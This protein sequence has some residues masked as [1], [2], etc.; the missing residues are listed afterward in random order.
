[1]KIAFDHHSPFLLAHGGFQIQI[2]QTFKAL[3]EEGV[4]V[5]WLRWWDDSQKPD[6]IHFFGTVYAGYLRY[7]S[8]KG[9]KTVINELHTGLGSHPIWKHRVQSAVI[10][11]SQK[12]LPP[13]AARMNWDNH[14]LADAIV[15]LTAYEADLMCNIFHAPRERMHVI[16]NG[17]DDVFFSQSQET[18]E[19][20]LVCTAVITRRKR[21]VELAEAAG[22]AGIPL[23]IYGRPYSEKDPYFQA[24]KKVLQKHEKHVRWE[25]S[26]TD[27][28]ELAKIYR[29]A[30]GFVLPST[31]ESLSLSALEAAACECPL[32]LVKL[33]WAT[34][35]FG[36]AASYLPNTSNS[37]KMAVYLKKFWEGSMR[38]DAGA[39]T[40]IF[41]WRDI[42]RKLKA[43]Y[44]EVLGPK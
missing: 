22:I 31:M 39:E 6:L 21:V 14:D 19:E 36:E 40:E 33:P 16:P 24:F 1:M 10:G 35:T 13:L 8:E 44:L 20:W 12:H 18:R 42:A 25:G 4:E 27:R 7:A 29:R 28:S 23:R 17:V 30:R 11:F 34:S 15:A 32:L 3:Q 43:L 2:E 37:E 38:A 26:V 5:E 9:I 41:R